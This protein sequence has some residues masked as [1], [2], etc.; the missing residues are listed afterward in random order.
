MV[1]DEY[2]ADEFK[3]GDETADLGENS[4]QLVRVPVILVEGLGEDPAEEKDMRLKL[5]A[6]WSHV[7][8]NVL[9]DC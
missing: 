2:E 7:C 4:A 1:F 5:P 3:K 6:V 9:E 8:L